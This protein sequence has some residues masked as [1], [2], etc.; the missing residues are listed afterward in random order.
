M[1]NQNQEIEN[2][3]KEI[4]DKQKK[5]AQLRLQLDPTPIK[6]YSFKDG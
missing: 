1:E 2:L 6:N 3:E 5:L 4:F